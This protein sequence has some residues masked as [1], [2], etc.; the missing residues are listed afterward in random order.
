MAAEQGTSA[1]SK[2][3]GGAGK[4]LHT[5]EIHVRRTKNKGYIAKHDLRD[6][7]GNPPKDGQR[8]EAEYALANKDA[9]LQHIAQHM[10]DDAQ[11]QQGEDEQEPQAQPQAAQ[12]QASPVQ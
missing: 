4:K 3:L 1:L 8:G 9:M 7:D 5:H 2:I 6:K 12:P 11:P 10:G